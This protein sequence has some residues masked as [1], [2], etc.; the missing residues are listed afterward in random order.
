MAINPNQARNAEHTAIAML[1]GGGKGVAINNLGIIDKRHPIIIFD[2][3]GEYEKIAGRKVYRYKTRMNFCKQFAKAWAS[4]KPFALAYHPQ[5]AGSTDKERKKSL[6][7]SAHWFGRLAWNASDGNR[8][9]Y[10]LFEEFG[11]YTQGS[12]DEDSIIGQIWTGGRKFGLRGI[13]AFQRAANVSKKIWENSPNKIIG[14]QGGKLDQERACREIGCTVADIVD[15]GSRNKALEMFASAID[16]NVRTKVHY[17]QSKAA[18]TFEK[19]ACYVPQSS[20]LTKKWSAKQR[21]IDQSG[22]YRIAS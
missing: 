6:T 16:E 11:E 2:P 1:T 20:Y 17:L 9:L 5:V 15:L 19:V 22:G 4:G 12:G 3:H 10:T 18:G 7:D 21:E 13:V 14:V 8:I